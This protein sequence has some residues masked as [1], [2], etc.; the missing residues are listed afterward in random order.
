MPLPAPS[1]PNAEQL[2]T[3]KRYLFIYREDREAY[4]DPDFGWENRIVFRDKEFPAGTTDWEVLEEAHGY[5]VFDFVENNNTCDDGKLNR[6]L[7]RVI[8]IARDLSI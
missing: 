4:V 2:S 3:M 8:Q 6:R 5:E 7:L 1:P